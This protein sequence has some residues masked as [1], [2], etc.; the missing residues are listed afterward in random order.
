MPQDEQYKG[1]PSQPLTLSGSTLFLHID[2]SGSQEELKA[3]LEKNLQEVEQQIQRLE[4]LLASEFAEKAPPQVVNKEK[5]R[6][7]A[8]KE[9][10]EKLKNQ[11]KA[12]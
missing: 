11:L 2:T 5:A 12:L 3:D 10:A 6:L 7:A 8:F 9:T 4:K 1:F